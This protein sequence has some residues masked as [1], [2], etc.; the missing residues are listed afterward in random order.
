[1]K[2]IVY[3]FTLCLITI[4]VSASDKQ[5]FAEKTEK[6]KKHLNID[7]I[8]GKD[9]SKAIACIF[10]VMTDATEDEVIVNPTTKA[11]TPAHRNKSLALTP[12]SADYAAWFASSPTNDQLK[13]PTFAQSPASRKKDKKS[14]R[15]EQKRNHK[16]SDEKDH[17]APESE[18]PSSSDNE[19]D[20]KPDTSSVLK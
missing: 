6:K 3:F 15:A 5:K 1:M 20:T 18:S 13:I 2:Y 17:K 12:R 11:L 8:T 14:S 16:V 10:V 9:T 19:P 4:S 7:P